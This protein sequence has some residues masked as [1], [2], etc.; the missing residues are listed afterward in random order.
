[1]G[2]Y[3]LSYE[4]L[5]CVLNKLLYSE[6]KIESIPKHVQ[7]ISGGVAGKHKLQIL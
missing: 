4:H 1:M 6:T 5:S 3:V 7:L 2:I